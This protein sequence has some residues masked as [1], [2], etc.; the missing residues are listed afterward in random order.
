MCGSTHLHHS[1]SIRHIAS[2]SA[3]FII[4]PLYLHHSLAYLGHSVEVHDTEESFSDAEED[5]G[6][7]EHH[8]QVGAVE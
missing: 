6:H 5:G 4:H 2:D 1:S 3:I 7:D 8:A